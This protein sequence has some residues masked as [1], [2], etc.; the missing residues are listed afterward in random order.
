M[1]YP[2]GS[3]ML[4]AA[5]PAQRELFATALAAIETALDENRVT[6]AEQIVTLV[7]RIAKQTG[8]PEH[9]ARAHWCSGLALLNW[10]HAE[11]LDHYS[12][13]RTFFTQHGP[14]EDAA[15]VL[16]GYGITAGYLGKLDEAEAALQ[17]AISH[18]APFPDH[19]HWMRLYLN[20]SVLEGLRGRYQQMHDY[21]CRTVAAAERH[22]HRLIHASALVNQGMAAMAL[23]QLDEANTVLQ[24]GLR[25]AG[26]AAEVRG[27]ALVNLA[28]VAI[29]QGRLFAALQV[30]HQARECF[31]AVD[32]QIDQATVA[33]EAA[34]L[35]ER[36][37]MLREAQQQAIFAADAFAQA[38]LPPESVEA[39]LLA[40][41]L[42]LARGR[43]REVQQ[44]LEQAWLLADASA[45]TWQALLHGYALHP[46]LLQKRTHM[47]DALARID[48]A[49][50]TLHELGAV[51]EQLDL[52]L[53]GADLAARLRQ[54]DALARYQEIAVTAHKHGMVG[55]EQRACVGQARLLRPRAACQPLRRAADLLTEQRRQ[56]P[57]EELKANL[58]SGAHTVYVQLVEAQLKSRQSDAAV[59]TL[60]EAKGGAW[61]D[62]AAPAVP[63]Q[64]DAAWL[65]TRTDLL[66]WQEERR[67][68]SDPAYIA[69]CEQRIHAA[70]AAHVA[71]TH[72]EVQHAAPLR[73]PPHPV[74]DYLVGTTHI[75]ACLFQ[76]DTPSHWVQVCTIEALQAIMGRFSLLVKSLQSDDSPEQRLIAARRQRQAI[77]DL[78]ARMYTL[79]LEPLQ[80]MLSAAGDLLI[81]PDALLFEL[82]WA[83]LRMPD[84]YLGERY[85]L[86]LLPSATVP[87]RSQSLQPGTPVA[88]GYAGDPPLVHIEA[89]LAMLQQ[90]FPL[91]DCR[92]PAST[93]DLS[94]ITTPD[95]LHIAAHGHIRRD[96]PLLSHLALAD[97][98]FL[99]AQALNLDLHSTRLVTLSACDTGTVPERGGVMLA[100]AGAFLVAGAATVLASLWPVEDAT[101]GLLMAAFYAAVQAGASFPQALQQAQHV[102][103]THGYD[104]PVYWSAFQLLARCV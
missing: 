92:H 83:A 56:M 48:A 59:E 42:A 82:P 12:A 37:H 5:P 96:A 84:G 19:P 99:L 35:Y 97:G 13:A 20:L 58:L 95:I 27:K 30:L 16:L 94:G 22:R 72:V 77:D 7:W 32:L 80:G 100:L 81:A 70:A 33:I 54:P 87:G 25:Q 11:A 2:T 43:T 9:Q 102:V 14:A 65:A 78:L 66:T 74:I 29:Y 91:L 103:R 104:H 1:A 75:Y 88:L 24:A 86:L 89:E 46:Q 93:H 47:P 18:L 34:S 8:E 79:L 15:R 55:L 52:A 49:T 98:P 17:Q 21:A 69:L 40:L 101:T 50:T 85:R 41:R 28:R 73:P 68:A 39:R 31:T 67:F 36:L 23:G 64:P 44:H 6:D 45:P 63:R 10:S 26:D 61:A 51:A 38:G 53:L 62:L 60:L 76:P 4:P 71:A 3:L 57:V 90:V